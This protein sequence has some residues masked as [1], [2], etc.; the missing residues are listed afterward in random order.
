MSF[1]YCVCVTVLIDNSDG[2]LRFGEMERDC[3]VAHG[4]AQFLHE[5]LYSVSDAY[6]I[7]VCDLCGLIAIAN[8][9]RNSYECRGCKNKTQVGVV[10]KLG[11]T[12]MGVVNDGC[13]YLLLAWIYSFS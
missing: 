5:R 7:T 1:L 8:I 10:S 11:V 6:K 9:Q 12:K 2:G 13:P 3:Q 4:A